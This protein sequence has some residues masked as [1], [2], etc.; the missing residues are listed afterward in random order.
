[1]PFQ[2][3]IERW[4]YQQISG[5]FQETKRQNHWVW[6]FWHCAR[7][8]RSSGATAEPATACASTFHDFANPDNFTEDQKLARRTL[9]EISTVFRND[10][11]TQQQIYKVLDLPSLWGAVHSE[12]TQ[13]ST[14]DRLVQ[15]GAVRALWSSNSLRHSKRWKNYPKTWNFFISSAAGRCCRCKSWS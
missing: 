10:N 7:L 11:K 8:H 5:S 12:R 4:I 13:E 15:G 3:I 1:M 2:Q 9:W 6:N 14:H